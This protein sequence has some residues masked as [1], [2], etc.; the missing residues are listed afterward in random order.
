MKDDDAPPRLA[1]HADLRGVDLRGRDLRGVDLRGADLRGADLRGARLS[2]VVGHNELDLPRTARELD[3]RGAQLEGVRWE[4]AV[5]S[6]LRGPLAPEGPATKPG[7][8]AG[9]RRDVP[10]ATAA[11]AAS[12]KT[13]R[14]PRRAPAAPPP[15]PDPRSVWVAL[16]TYVL[17]RVPG[18]LELATGLG[19]LRWDEAADPSTLTRHEVAQIE[20]GALRLTLHLATEHVDSSAGPVVAG[21]LESLELHEDGAIR[22]RVERRPPGPPRLV[23][24]PAELTALLTEPGSLLR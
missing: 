20:H 17:S 22:I 4:G 2:D 11:V 3:L 12:P 19:T 1:P 9:R 15:A 24:G 13:R 23:L 8:A 5:G 6:A 14:R 7:R 18:A 10:P 21:R 16:A